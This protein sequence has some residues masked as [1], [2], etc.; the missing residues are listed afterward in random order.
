MQNNIAGCIEIISVT[1]ENNYNPLDVVGEIE[2]VGPDFVCASTND[3]IF[4]LGDL[5]ALG[6]IDWTYTGTDV[7]I[8]E[9]GF[10]ANL[11]FGNGATGGL[12]IANLTEDCGTLADTLIIIISDPA[13]CVIANCPKSAEITNSII[14]APGAPHVYRASA[15]LTLNVQIM[16]HDYQFSG[17]TEVQFS[18]GFEFGIGSNLLVEIK[19]CELPISN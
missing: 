2:I 13:L 10:G 9:N 12:L 18:N 17:G 4:E 16:M 11:D 7:Q 6:T 19:D 14:D 1:L 3:V 5:P 15:D 8:I